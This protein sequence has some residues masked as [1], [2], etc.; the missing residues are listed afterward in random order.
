M[1]VWIDDGQTHHDVACLRL[2]HEYD[3]DD[4][5]PLY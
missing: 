5:L 3:I 2:Y 4:L 1:L